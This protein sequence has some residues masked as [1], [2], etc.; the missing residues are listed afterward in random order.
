[1][2]MAAVAAMGITRTMAVMV[3]TDITGA[4]D[5]IDA[6][7]VALVVIHAADLMV[8]I[9][10]RPLLPAV[11]LR[12]QHQRTDLLRTCRRALMEEQFRQSQAEWCED[13]NVFR[14][15]SASSASAA[16]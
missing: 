13:I 8:M 14:D 9:M 6:A 12:P 2:D 3:A 16:S 1:M 7:G 5:I 4:T 15:A 10:A 11:M